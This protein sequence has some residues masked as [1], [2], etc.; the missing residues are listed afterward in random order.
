MSDAP[1]GVMLETEKKLCM[2]QQCRSKNFFFPAC[3]ARYG[4]LQSST[5]SLNLGICSGL[6]CSFLENVAGSSTNDLGPE[7]IRNYC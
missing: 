6:L 1:F 5:A 2:Q 4:K 7:E 3:R